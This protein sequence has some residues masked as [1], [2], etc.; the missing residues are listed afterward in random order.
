MI[1]LFYMG[2]PERGS[3]AP[4][5]VVGRYAIYDTI[6]AGGTATV[7]IGRLSDQ[8][9]FARTVAIKRL[10]PQFARDPDFVVAFLDEAR[11]SARIR[12]PNV[13]QT[14]DVVAGDGELFLVMEY[15]AG[16]SLATLARS[17]GA[18]G[19][20]IP[21]PIVSAI[22]CGALHGLHAAHEAKNDNGEPLGVV[23]RDISPQNIMVDIDGVAR[24]LDFGIAKA[25]LQ[26]HTTREGQIK[27]KMAYM[28]PEQ[29]S[30]RPA[31]R[32]S[33]VFSASV[34]L[35]EQLTGSRLFR[36][37]NESALYVKVMQE[38]IAPP[39]SLVPALPSAL[40]AVVL[41]GLERDVSRRFETAQQMAVTLEEALAPATARRVGDWVRT[42]CSENVGA[43][44]KRVEEI[45]MMSA[46]G[47]PPS[48]A[49]PVA[50]LV[51]NEPRPVSEKSSVAL[52]GTRARSGPRVLAVGL[53]LSAMAAAFIVKR[54]TAPSSQKAGS[55]T[56]APEV[57]AAD[58]A[59]I[60]PAGSPTSTVGSLT[61]ASAPTVA[62][63]VTPASLPTGRSLHPSV[64]RKP[65][66]NPPYV[67]DTFGVRIAK[68]ECL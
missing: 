15:I 39:S 55:Q 14:L 23:H 20:R 40:D 2:A 6:A 34:V 57:V 1:A 9:G 56:T 13:V 46:T 68:R 5:V 60:S 19:E 65:N 51:S 16:E 17:L 44:Q 31:T 62:A 28:A 37:D 21:P 10:H 48:T 35:W 41:R 64:L 63:S 50:P 47:L 58:T 29:I 25:L 11:L 42:A 67:V 24:V 30:G 59:S 33:D 36:A 54:R 66:C 12:H 61:V 8:V 45:E 32:Q 52:A 27:G 53:V 7:H 18:R 43:R 3:T 49:P 22:L 26:S 38:P 4:G